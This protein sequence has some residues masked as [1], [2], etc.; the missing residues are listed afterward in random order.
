MIAVLIERR[1]TRIPGL[2]RLRRR[3]IA[4]LGRWDGYYGKP[5][6]KT[7]RIG[8]EAFER[9]KFGTALGLHDV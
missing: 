3:V 1:E 9:I 7:M 8:L 2:A 4:H 5:G 6:P